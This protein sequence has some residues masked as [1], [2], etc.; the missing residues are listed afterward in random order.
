ML[1][2]HICRMKPRDDEFISS[3]ASNV[4]QSLASSSY[5]EKLDDLLSPED[6]SGASENC[7][8]TY[9]LSETIL[10]A[11][12]FERDDLSD[13]F[14][15]LQSKGACCDCEVLYNVAEKSRLKAKYW[16]SRAA[17]LPTKMTHKPHSRLAKI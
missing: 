8:G 7:D 1:Y 13:I 17:G 6:H 2:L 16:R 12:G 10:Q 9:K 15:V 4:M 11:S 5:F 3:I 14:A